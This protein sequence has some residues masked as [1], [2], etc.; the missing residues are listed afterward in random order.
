VN[1]QIDENLLASLNSSGVQTSIASSVDVTLTVENDGHL[2][3]T[4]KT[5]IIIIIFT[6]REICV[7]CVIALHYLMYIIILQKYK[8]MLMHLCTALLI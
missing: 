3:P 6:H 1:L 2:E 8:M 4:I 5:I 7:G